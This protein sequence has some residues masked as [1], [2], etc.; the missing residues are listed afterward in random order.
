MLDNINLAPLPT[1]R[2]ILIV[3][4]AGRIALVSYSEEAYYWTG[5]DTWSGEDGSWDDSQIIGWVEADRYDDAARVAKAYLADV[6]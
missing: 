2:E 3:D 6:P 4:D 5:R 1:D